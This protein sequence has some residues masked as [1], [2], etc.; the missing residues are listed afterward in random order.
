[1]RWRK[2]LLGG[3]AGAVVLVVALAASVVW[4]LRG[5]SFSPP[6]RHGGGWKRPPDSDAP[7]AAGR[8][9][10]EVLHTF[11]EHGDYVSGL[12]FS[13]DATLLVSA[14]HDGSVKVHDI[15][16]GQLKHDLRGHGR[17]GYG[18]A[19]AVAID[20]RGRF[21][22]TTDNA[23]VLRVFD[24]S[25]GELLHTFRGAG[26]ELT[27]VAYSAG[28]ATL[29]TAS[30]EPATVEVRS[31]ED[32]YK[33]L[34]TYPDG[35]EIAEL[36]LAPD[37]AAVATA[38]CF[39]RM[40]LRHVPGGQVES[41][42]WLWPCGE[43]FSAAFSSDLREAAHAADAATIFRWDVER[44]TSLSHL[45]NPLGGSNM[46]GVT[47]L[48]YFP[49]DEYLAA[50]TVDG[51]VE[52]WHLATESLVAEIFSVLP[53]DISRLAFSADGRLLA[54]GDWSGGIRLLRITLYE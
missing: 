36:A 52:F 21:L 45:E 46:E 10:F 16:T 38:A 51:R 33:V 30:S 44:G 17:K 11:S 8:I 7:T 49:G 54:V 28:G 15:A 47:A 50:G 4:M 5:H 31:V 24:L 20:L 25:S 40:K 35:Q 3:C 1:M 29:V 27:A 18:H 53:H 9:R 22:A 48:A 43:Y 12:A 23:A 26:E 14:S 19:T 41:S 37:A 39:E 13:P 34:E 2:L 32:G 42:V 6:A